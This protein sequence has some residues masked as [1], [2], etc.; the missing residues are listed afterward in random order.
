M[1]VLKG[2]G[3][4]TSYKQKVSR[5]ELHRIFVN[6]RLQRSMVSLNVEGSESLEHVEFM[7]EEHI[8]KLDR[9]GEKN[10][11][12][13]NSHFSLVSREM[14]A[15]CKDMECIFLLVEILSTKVDNVTLKVD[16]IEVAVEATIVEVLMEVMGLQDPSSP[17]T[18]LSIEPKEKL[19]EIQM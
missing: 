18:I 1:E 12:E 19:L 2:V 17:R 15:L 8:G 3:L 10:V 5:L 6:F 11:L 14:E 13:E 9:V 16:G 7:G 4:S